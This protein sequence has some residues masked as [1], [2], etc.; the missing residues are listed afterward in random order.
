MR[1][2]FTDVRG[3]SDCRLRD[4]SEYVQEDDDHHERAD[5]HDVELLELAQRLELA[6]V[7]RFLLMFLETKSRLARPKCPETQKG[8]PKGA[9]HF[10]G[11]GERT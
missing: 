4:E 9:Y 2:G 7:G 3:S 1:R 10:D 6:V 11:A 8:T 5:D